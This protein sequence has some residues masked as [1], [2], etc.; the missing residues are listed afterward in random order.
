[1]FKGK[2]KSLFH[3]QGFK[4]LDLENSTNPYYTEYPQARSFYGN[5]RSDD[6]FDAIG[7]DCTR[8]VSISGKVNVDSEAAIADFRSFIGSNDVEAEKVA[9]AY[10]QALVGQITSPLW[11]LENVQKLEQETAFINFFKDSSNQIYYVACLH[12]FRITSSDNG[13]EKSLN[14]PG[15]VLYIFSYDH[16]DEKFHLKYPLASNDLLKELYEKNRK[17]WE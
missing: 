10:S 8:G 3:L 6:A 15:E 13:S 2:N 12:N 14:L 4:L 11:S 1:M 9:R 17:N 5:I 7:F 16:K